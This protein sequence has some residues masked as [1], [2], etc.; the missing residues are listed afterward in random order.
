MIKLEIWASGSGSNAE[1]LIEF[2]RNHQFIKINA[3]ATDNPNAGVIE[4]AKKLNV[5]CYVQTKEMRLSNEYVVRL[6]SEVDGII[7]AGYLRLVNTRII[8]AFDGKIINLHPSLLPLYGGKGMYGINVHQAVLTNKETVSGIT[9]HQVN[10]QFDEG[11]IIAQFST[12][13]RE[14]ENISELQ[15]KIQQLEHQYFPKVVELYF[16]KLKSYL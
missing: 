13:I 5:P 1:R 10:E 11:E 15:K 6:K 16:T 3:I 14:I 4:R 2:F 8:K 12:P 9:I 7:L